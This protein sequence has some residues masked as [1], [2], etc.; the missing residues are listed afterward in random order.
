MQ[1]PYYKAYDLRYR[2]VH[3]EGLRWFADEPTA[4]VREVLHRFHITK[5]MPILEI[6]C[7]E[8]RDAIPLLCE[9]YSLLATDV[10]EEA[11]RYVSART[12]HADAVRVFDALTDKLDKDFAFIYAVAVLHM[13]VEDADR[14]AFYRT[15]R[16][17]LREDGLSLVCSMGDGRTEQCTDPSR[18][19]EPQQRVHEATGRT[20]TIASTTCR[21]ATTDILIAEAEAAGLRVIECGTCRIDPDYATVTYLLLKKA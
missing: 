19:F 16:T 18:A 17:H 2:Q 3:A 1:L 14:A 13:L 6:G 7:G 4:L 8:G 21:M 15:I 12:E 10:S 5:D 11:V 9:G 20:L